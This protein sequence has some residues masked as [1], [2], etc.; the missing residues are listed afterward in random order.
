M[1]LVTDIDASQAKRIFEIIY[2]E[3]AIFQGFS[4]AEVEAMSAVFK[5]LSFK[6]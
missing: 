4:M 2:E 6:K 5:I 1:R 3:T